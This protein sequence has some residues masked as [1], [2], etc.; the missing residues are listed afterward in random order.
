MGARTFI[1][2]SIGK[3]PPMN[4]LLFYWPSCRSPAPPLPPPLVFPSVRKGNIPLASSVARAAAALPPP[5]LHFR[6][7]MNRELT[8]LTVRTFERHRTQ[9]HDKYFFNPHLRLWTSGFRFIV[10]APASPTRTVDLSFLIFLFNA[11]HKVSR[12][13]ALTLHTACYTHPPTQLAYVST[14]MLH[15]YRRKTSSSVIVR[16]F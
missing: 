15:F 4:K 5:S 11:V 6:G 12:C 3:D 14:Q 13:Y 7:C 10:S 2:A 9:R 8:F 1:R 16:L